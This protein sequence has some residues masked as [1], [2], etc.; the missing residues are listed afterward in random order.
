MFRKFNPQEL[1]AARI[2]CLEEI[3]SRRVTTSFSTAETDR[4]QIICQAAE[5][6]RCQ[7]V[8]VTTRNSRRVCKMWTTWDNDPD[9]G[10][11]LYVTAEQKE[12]SA[13]PENTQ[14]TQTWDLHF[15]LTEM[16]YCSLFAAKLWTHFKYGCC[17][18]EAPKIYTVTTLS[19]WE[20]KISV[21]KKSFCPK[22]GCLSY[23]WDGHFDW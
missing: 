1:L 21:N 3:Y 14:A 11:C 13:Q 16:F 22:N 5:N 19:R 17:C 2:T 20:P 7:Y 6:R 15:A 9:R 4:D 23:I 10:M 8:Y 12:E 18:S